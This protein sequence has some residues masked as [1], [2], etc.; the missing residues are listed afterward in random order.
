M[1]EKTEQLPLVRLGPGW[2][3][4]YK[5]VENELSSEVGFFKI[6]PNSDK[7]STGKAQRTFE[8]V[9]ISLKPN[10]VLVIDGGTIIDW[11]TTGGGI[12]LLRMF[13]KHK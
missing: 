12:A 6:I 7:M 1:E 2:L 9:S 5:A 8:R 13:E 10:Q 3:Y 4:F 11:P